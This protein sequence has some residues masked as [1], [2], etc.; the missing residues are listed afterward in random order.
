MGSDS[1]LFKSYPLIFRAA[2]N[3]H[4]YQHSP[5]AH[6][7]IECG[8]GWY[9]IIED[10]AA[11]LEGEASALKAAG[12]RPPVIVQVKEKFGTLTVHVGGF[13]VKRYFSELR[14]RLD[15]AIERSK[16][17]CEI[18]GASGTFREDGWARTR[19]DKCEA[20]KAKA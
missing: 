11:W 3:L 16:T 19:C 4:H 2:G 9:P 8:E 7:G 17:V 6:R 18:C 20:E 1:R 15:A 12:K 5:I 10:M 14:P 13:P